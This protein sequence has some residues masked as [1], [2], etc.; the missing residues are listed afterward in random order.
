MPRD[1]NDFLNLIKQIGI[2]TDSWGQILI[3]LV[4]WGGGSHCSSCSSKCVPLGPDDLCCDTVSPC[5]R[6]VPR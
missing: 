1:M 4:V 5:A 2:R 3:L 6:L